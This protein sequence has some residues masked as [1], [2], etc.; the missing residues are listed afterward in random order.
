MKMGQKA[1]A[2]RSAAAQGYSI[3]R[4]YR[5]RWRRHGLATTDFERIFEAV[6]QPYL[7]LAP[8]FI[9]IGVNRAYL[10]ATM[11]VREQIVGRPIFTVF[12]DTPGDHGADGVHNLGRSLREVLAH[13]VKHGMQWQ[14]HDIRT[15]TGIVV[16]RHWNWDNLPVLD[17]NGDVEFIV[18]HLRDVTET[19]KAPTSPIEIVRDLQS[20]IARLRRLVRDNHAV[21]G[22][23]RGNGSRQKA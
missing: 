10:Q 5:S 20:T 19:V 22:L 4:Q 18:H 11:T 12:P 21:V 23:N 15:S 17:R 7:V 1:V 8:S 3:H 16:E 14:R 2:P 13:K 9:I 6:A